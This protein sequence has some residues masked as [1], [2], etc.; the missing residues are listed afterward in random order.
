MNDAINKSIRLQY[1][2]QFSIYCCFCK[3]FLIFLFFGKHKQLLRLLQ[4]Q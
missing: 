4:Q 3:F 2:E 1:L